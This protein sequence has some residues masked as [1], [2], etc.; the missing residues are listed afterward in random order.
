LAPSDNVADAAKASLVDPHEPINQA[1]AKFGSDPQVPKNVDSLGIRAKIFYSAGNFKESA[2]DYRAIIELQPTDHWDWFRRG[3]LLAYL[4]KTEAYRAHCRAMLERFGDTKDHF[5]AD[6]TGKTCLL[7]AEVGGDPT[8]L[9]ELVDRALA[10]GGPP[11]NLHWFQMAK[12]MAEYRAGH[13]DAAI[14]WLTRSQ[15]AQTIASGIAGTKA[16]LSMAHY[17]S[18]HE[19]QARDL[20]AQANQGV[21]RDLPKAGVDELPAADM[22]NWLIAHIALREAKALVGSA[23]SDKIGR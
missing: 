12:G 23:P 17:R 18:G 14:D 15:K 6:R 21:E 13:F 19:T 20:L 9:S 16:Y 3:C 8:Q 11:D 2:E 10:S 7:L 1:L 5:I 22:E 4:N